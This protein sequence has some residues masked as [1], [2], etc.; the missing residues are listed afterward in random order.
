MLS[1]IQLWIDFWEVD[2]VKIDQG[3][4]SGPVLV[5]PQDSDLDVCS[6]AAASTCALLPQLCLASWE[7]GS[8]FSEG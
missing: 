1:M 4:R 8:S 7:L 5:P 2:Q 6:S 3:F